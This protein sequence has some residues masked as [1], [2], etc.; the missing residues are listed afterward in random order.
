MTADGTRIIFVNQVFNTAVTNLYFVIT[1]FFYLTIIVSVVTYYLNIKLIRDHW[2]VFS[3]FFIQRLNITKYNSFTN[4][5]NK[6]VFYKMASKNQ[7]VIFNNG[8]K[9]PILGFG[10]WKVKPKS[11]YNDYFKHLSISITV[12][13]FVK[14]Y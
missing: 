12:V 3:F 1:F 11:L 10:T 4:P 14:W 8:Q 5:E 7:F 13:I 6:R 2:S 9:Y